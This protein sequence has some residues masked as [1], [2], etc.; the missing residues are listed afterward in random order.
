MTHYPAGRPVTIT[1]G[2]YAGCEGMVAGTKDKTALIQIG[3]RWW[4]WLP[5]AN[6]KPLHRAV[7]ALMVF[8]GG[9]E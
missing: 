8:D 6:I 1:A 7:A 3:P 4:E 5:L 9:R 2:R